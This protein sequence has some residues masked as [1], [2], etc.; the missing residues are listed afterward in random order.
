MADDDQP[1]GED[2][3]DPEA[4][5]EALSRLGFPSSQFG[6]VLEP[7]MTF[8]NAMADD[9]DAR[10]WVPIGPR[11]MAGAVRA[12]AQDPANPNTIWAGSSQGGLWRS[13]DA[14]STWR[15]Q[16]TRDQAFSVGALTFG[17][18]LL[19][20]GSG[21]PFA[22]YA[23]GRGLFR[24]SDGG[25]TLARMV[26]PSG[27]DGAAEHYWR[28]RIDP[29]EPRRIWVA[30]TTGLWRFEPDGSA[31]REL[32]PVAA[33]T[34]RGA[35]QGATDVVLAPDPADPANR[36]F[37]VAG[38]SEQGLWRRIWDR[39]TP[40][41]TGGA[42]AWS[43]LTAAPLD[44]IDKK[45]GRARLA[46]CAQLPDHVYAMFD[47]QGA[48]VEDAARPKGHP[49]ELYASSDHGRTW[50]RRRRLYT[51]EPAEPDD[52][53]EGIAW[54]ALLLEVHPVDPN[55][56]LAGSVELFA[57]TI[58]GG[59]D[60]AGDRSWKKILNAG[61]YDRDHASH[62]DQHA[63]L[64]DASDPRNLY[65]GNDGGIAFTP[66]IDGVSTKWR[67]RSYGIQITELNDV[68]VH[69]KLPTFTGAGLQDQSTRVSYGGPTWYPFG[70]GDGGG[71]AFEPDDPRIVY[72]MWQGQD[73][74][75]H[76]G[77]QRN[78]VAVSASVDARVPLP[79]LGDGPLVEMTVQ[80]EQDFNWFPTDNGATF[81]GIIEHHPTRAGDVLI[82]R[83]LAAFHSSTGTTF[84]R[85]NT[86]AF[87]TKPPDPPAPALKSPE[88][89]TSALA[90]GTGDPDREWW[91][92][93]ST[94]D[95][96]V[97]TDGGGAWANRSPFTGAHGPWISRIAI[98]PSN[99]SVVAIATGAFGGR[100]G[101]VRLSHD[102]GQHWVDLA[103]AGATALPPCP[104]VGLV[105]DPSDPRVLY[106]GTLVGVVVTRNL[107]APTGAALTTL[108]SPAE[109]RRY[110]ANLPFSLITDLAIVPFNGTLR[111]ATYGRGAF[112]CNLPT[113]PADR[114]M[115]SVRLSIRSHVMDDGRRY[116]A[117]QRIESDPRRPAA[118]GLSWIRSVD[119]RVD[120]PGIRLFD[121][122][123]FGEALDGAELDQD[124]PNDPPSLGD[125]NY[126]YVQV[127]NR[128]TAEADGVNVDLYWAKTPNLT[129][130]PDLQAG[131]WPPGGGD[132]PA[133]AW[134][135]AAP[136]QQL[137]NLRPGEPQVARFA[138]TPPPDAGAQVALLAVCSST[139]DVLPATRPSAIL[140]LVQAE[141][142]A[143]VRVMPTVGNPL[144][145]R[146]GVDDSGQRAGVAWGGHTPDII[147]AAADI[148]PAALDVTDLDYTRPLDRVTVGAN[149][150][151]VRVSNR[152]GASA[153]AS[154][155][156]Y[157]APLAK[158]ARPAEWRKLTTPSMA[159]AD[160]PANGWKL[161]GPIDWTPTAAELPCALVVLMNQTGVTPEPTKPSLDGIDSLDKLWRLLRTD[162]GSDKTAIR[163]LRTA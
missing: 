14:G 156:V 55:L 99:P 25:Q 122:F 94:G 130:A 79:D 80:N 160:V 132:P 120:A 63:A 144:Y 21:E 111:C 9:P 133:G 68:T 158:L 100:P 92:G 88:P 142:H 115:P 104:V 148:D 135:R 44:H 39:R 1:D 3:D 66:R 152:S 161:A 137:G 59:S 10:P 123:R 35:A 140:D 74:H 11:N 47:D 109:W 36:L 87:T 116:P 70:I 45:I 146:N 110:S 107:P 42:L 53:H 91:V 108:T 2:D 49:T 126:V 118:E 31:H 138:W 29:S 84:D 19:Y 38:I 26:G 155:D 151:W 86:G 6:S 103:G 76:W 159:L 32:S 15:P 125:V 58:G 83:R 89:Q 18:N 136:R 101:Q 17:G 7:A 154:L 97:T 54:Y 4:R 69:P 147:V 50:E 150:I 153:S 71:T 13:D 117:A 81:V 27:A 23:P 5:L 134:Q 114:A 37:L 24:S 46:L 139:A 119:I 131:L 75:H 51:P 121:R 129:G 162:P 67:G 106:A 163:I 124:L 12:L 56:V 34:Q 40:N 52:P 77:L 8:M 128:G 22:H 145:L 96:F 61:Q 16:G 102:R 105:F 62:A 33:P 82:G 64:W 60:V 85:L 157:C 90:Y 112:E 73:I 127:H 141:P 149:K 43:R 143:A 30:A 78:H 41:D 48:A 65:V 113:T 98:S 93:T 20:V 28:I 57:S 95:V 72:S